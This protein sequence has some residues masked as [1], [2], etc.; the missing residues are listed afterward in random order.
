MILKGAISRLELIID[1]DA[2]DHDY[3]WIQDALKE[4][5]EYCKDLERAEGLVYLKRLLDLIGTTCT[6]DF[7]ADQEIMKNRCRFCGV[8][9]E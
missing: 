2:F 7:H 6:H 9:Q 3:E 5:L 1:T 8:I 4:I